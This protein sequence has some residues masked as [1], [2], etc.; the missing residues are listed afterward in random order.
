ME[1]VMEKQPIALAIA[2]QPGFVPLN[3]HQQKLMNRNGIEGASEWV[4]NGFEFIVM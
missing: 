1:I 3:R 2:V 4:Y